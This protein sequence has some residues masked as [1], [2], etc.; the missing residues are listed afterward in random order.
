MSEVQ[1]SVVIPVRNAATFVRGLCDCLDHQTLGRDDF[2]VIFVDDSS[3]DGTAAALDGWI[4]EHP[5]RRRLLRSGGR[6]PG[7]ARNAGLRVARAPWIAFTDAD[8][9]PE[10][11]WLRLGLAVGEDTGADIVEGAIEPE[12]EPSTP[13]ERSVANDR[14]GLYMTANMLYRRRLLTELDGFDERFESFLEDSDLA[15]RALERGAK[16]VWAPNV[17]VRHR[18]YRSGFWARLHSVRR[19]QWVPLFRARHPEAYRRVLRDYVRP[20]SSVDV[21]VVLALTAVVALPRASS[22]ARI[23]LGL[24]AVNGLRRGIGSS[25]L[26]DAS[27]RDMPE[28]AALTVVAPILRVFWWLLGCAR[29]RMR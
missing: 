9:L 26:R 24:V 19:V 2:E 18:V 29:T 11:E 4:R 13:L 17:R 25:R 20:F 21:D 7:H 5:S 12:R 28:V 23:A 6:G 27:P 14:G 3:T 22:R 1:V 10:P 8:T 16:A 15:L